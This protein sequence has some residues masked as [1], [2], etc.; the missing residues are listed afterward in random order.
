MV[1]FLSFK[2]VFLFLAFQSTFFLRKT[3]YPTSDENGHQKIT[4]E[5]PVNKVS[6]KGSQSYID[7]SDNDFFNC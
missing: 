2:R 6:R 7:N 3:G 4:I 5:E 1:L